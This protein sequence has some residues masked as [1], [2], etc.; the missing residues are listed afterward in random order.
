M[1]ACVGYGGGDRN[2]S[3]GERSDR[4]EQ[5]KAFNLSDMTAAFPSLGK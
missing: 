3:R 2:E 4:N 1:K 5:P